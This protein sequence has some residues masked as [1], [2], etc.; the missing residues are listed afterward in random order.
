MARASTKKLSSEGQS[1]EESGESKNGEKIITTAGTRAVSGNNG[2]MDSE[3]KSSA[4][5]RKGRQRTQTKRSGK[6]KTELQESEEGDIEEGDTIYGSGRSA[7]DRY[8]AYDQDRE[9]YGRSERRISSRRYDD[10]P[11]SRALGREEP[12]ESQYGEYRSSN[13]YPSYLRSYGDWNDYRNNYAGAPGRREEYGY[14]R[15]PSRYGS[16]EYRSSRRY[17]QPYQGDWQQEYETG[18]RR[19]RGEWEEGEYSSSHRGGRGYE[20][21]GGEGYMTDEEDYSDRSPGDVRSA[22]H[23]DWYAEAPPGS[24]SRRG[25]RGYEGRS[26][27]GSGNYERR[28][29]S[30]RASGK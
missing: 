22:V 16:G 7:E 11:Y 12:Y 24:S 18:P 10:R 8:V 28:P 2:E 17:G 30:R 14:S 21:E 23:R 5:K 13:N 4:G 9:Q 6:D 25:Y 29:Y 3:G 1:S 20:P 15:Y 19:Q 27:R 26:Q